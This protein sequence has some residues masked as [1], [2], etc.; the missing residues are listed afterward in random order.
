MLTLNPAT[1]PQRPHY[2]H[3]PASPCYNVPCNVTL[4]SQHK[5]KKSFL[6]Y[7]GKDGTRLCTW[8][9]VMHTPPKI[10]LVAM[11]PAKFITLTSH[12]TGQGVNLSHSIHM[13]SETNAVAFGSSG[14]WYDY[15][16]GECGEYTRKKV[17]IK[18]WFV[19]IKL[20]PSD[21]SSHKYTFE[22]QEF[23]CNS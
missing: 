23:N 1:G 3:G 9:A 12:T 21:I 8:L 10:A 16:Y 4:S 13:H 20:K 11:A 15:I 7:S 22:F 14:G 17:L 18:T 6:S 2:N 19:T 5:V